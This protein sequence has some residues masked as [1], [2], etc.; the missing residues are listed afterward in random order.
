MNAGPAIGAGPD[1]ANIRDLADPRAILATSNA[2]AAVASDPASK[3]FRSKMA[4]GIAVMTSIF[5][6][7]KERQTQWRIPEATAAFLV[8]PDLMRSGKS[9]P[10][11]ILDRFQKVECRR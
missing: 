11:A 6:D 9:D 8:H 3:D 5:D 4:S 10:N 1:A 2:I 7:D